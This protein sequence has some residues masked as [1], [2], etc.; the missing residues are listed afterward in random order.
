MH[1]SNSA[2]T[3]SNNLLLYYVFLGIHRL[4]SP[5]LKYHWCVFFTSLNNG[6]CCCQFLLL[7]FTK[8]LSC[9]LCMW[10]TVEISRISVNWVLSVCKEKYIYRKD[11]NWNCRKT[12]KTNNCWFDADPGG[13]GVLAV[14]MTEGSE[15]ASYCEPK[16]LHKPEI[17]RPKKYLASKLPIKKLEDLNTSQYWVIQS[18]RL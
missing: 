13:G 11:W 14:Y 7:L 9:L 3:C 4:G 17:L 12:E 6:C 15:G 16:K 18:N 1:K 8:E 10:F 5:R 2:F